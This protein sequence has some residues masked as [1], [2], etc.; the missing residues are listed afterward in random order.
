MSFEFIIL[1]FHRIFPCSCYVIGRTKCSALF[2]VLFY[3]VQLQYHLSLTCLSHHIILPTCSLDTT[4][5]FPC[6][7]ASLVLLHSELPLWYFRF[8]Y[9]LLELYVTHLTEV[10]ITFT[11]AFC[12]RWKDIGCPWGTKNIPK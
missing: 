6:F 12:T 3:Q 11:S 1:Q 9:K 4:F 8:G 2:P 7:P 10:R 5:F